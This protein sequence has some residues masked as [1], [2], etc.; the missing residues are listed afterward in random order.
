MGFG[1]LRV[2]NDDA[3][4][5]ETGFGMHP[6]RD[7]EIITVV[8]RGA[9][10][11]KD[12]EGHHGITKAGQIQY[13]SAGRGIYH[14]E[15][16]PSKS[17]LLELFQIWIKPREKGLAPHYD[18]RDFSAFDDRN[19]WVALVSPD[20]REGSMAIAQDAYIST[21]RL[22][23]GN[24]LV[25]RLL[26]SGNGRLLFVVEGEV[27]V[28]EQLLMPRDE[29]QLSDEEEVVIRANSAARVMVFDVPM[30]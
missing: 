19:R 17:E 8:T 10:E 28:G 24:T 21:A 26:R 13:M 1:V 27:F 29:A 5:P 11:H 7:M 23:A 14:S 12:S 16:N 30:R 4:E 15:F 20:G 2:I 22:D 6:H 25:S 18:Q 3:I 9:V